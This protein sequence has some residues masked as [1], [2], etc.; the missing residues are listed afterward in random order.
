VTT[1][2]LVVAETAILTVTDAVTV[3]Q[4]VALD[5]KTSA[6]LVLTG[7]I[8]DTAANLAPAGTASAGLTAA[9]TQDPD[10]AVTI[11]GTAPTVAEL[12]RVAGLTTGAV[13]ATVATAGTINTGAG[14]D[15]I[16]LNGDADYIISFTSNVGSDVIINTNGWVTAGNDKIHIS[17]AAFATGNADNTIDA[18]ETQANAAAV[19]AAAEL[20]VVQTNAGTLFTA[21]D[22]SSV[23]AGK[24]AGV[25]ALAFATA[26]TGG[27]TKILAF[28]DGANTAVFRFVSAATDTTILQAELTLIGI[29]MGV[30]ATAHGDYAF[31]S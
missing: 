19:T 17:M 14:S 18:G 13:T 23:A 31:I 24:A 21:T 4:L 26:V 9:T 15:V 29:F 1:A 16:T 20:V 10:V 7:G 30:T 11:T 28:D 25:T 22:S 6:N 8:S 12:N 5:A 27:V 3:A 2:S